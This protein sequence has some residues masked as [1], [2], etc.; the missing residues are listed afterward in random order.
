MTGPSYNKDVTRLPGD[1][2]KYHPSNIQYEK[3]HKPDPEE[4]DFFH[5]FIVIGYDFRWCIPY[6][7]GKKNGKMNS[8]VYCAQILPALKSELLRRGGEYML[9]QDLDSAHKSARSKKWLY[10]NG[11][12]YIMA[13]PKSPDMSISETWTSQLRRAFYERS[14]PSEAAGIAR[15]YKVWDQLSVKKINN[16]VDGYRNRLVNICN[17]YQGAASKY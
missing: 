6:K 8:E 17:I 11:I 2:N 12:N 7:T 5:I 14:C 3:D 9:Y 10:H 15:F 1:K 13:P 4:Q 16:T